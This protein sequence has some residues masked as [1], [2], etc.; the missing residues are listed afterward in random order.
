MGKS[1][2]VGRGCVQREACDELFSRLR[3][4][5]GGQELIALAGKAEVL[6]EWAG[7]VRQDHSMVGSLLSDAVCGLHSAA[8]GWLERRTCSSRPLP[9]TSLPRFAGPSHPHCRNHE[10]TGTLCPDPCLR[11]PRMRVVLKGMTLLFE[12]LSSR[13]AATQ[14]HV[15]RR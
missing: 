15:R 4:E 9:L 6:G 12:S 1:A 7:I 3:Q 2:D 10:G 13:R 14:P 5:E 11:R 8:C